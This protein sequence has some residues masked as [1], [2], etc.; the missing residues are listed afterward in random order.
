MGIGGA[1]YFEP[2]TPKKSRAGA[3]A[4]L[5]SF[6]EGYGWLG[7]EVAHAGSGALVAF[8]SSTATNDYPYLDDNGTANTADDRTVNRQNADF[9]AREAWAVG[10]TALGDRGARVTTVFNAFDR[11]QGVSGIAAVPALAAR[12]ETA[13]VL[14]GISAKVPCSSDPSCVL[15]FVTQGISARSSLRDPRRELGLLVTRL[16]SRGDRFGESAR[17]TDA[18]TNWRALFGANFEAESLALDGKSALRAERRTGSARAALGWSLG[19]GLSSDLLA[20]AS[21]DQTRG[22]NGSQAC[23]DL[24]P[25]GRIGARYELGP[26]ALRGNVGR[27]QRVPT[28]GELYGISPLVRGSAALVPERGSIFDLGARSETR[29]GA[30]RAYADAG[31]FVREVSDLIAYRRSSLGAITPYNVGSARVLGAELEAGAES[32]RHYRTSLSLTVLDPRDTT[33][34]RALQNDLVPYQSRFVTS[35]FAEGFVDPHSR[36]VELV[37]LDARYDYRASRFA[38]PAGLIV[39][40]ATSELDLGT[41]LILKRDITVRGAIDDVFDAHHY[42]FIGYPVPGRSYHLSL[43]AWW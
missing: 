25:Q 34:N 9:T 36:S 30:V 35:L 7:G 27:Y 39:L 4:G 17:L 16:D 21:C 32:L 3:G 6:G 37:S 29:L 24:T 31:G 43:E 18:G 40:P 11:E 22:P 12:A 19:A 42:D 28:L 5:G 41:S 10:R 2:R 13:R 20:V 23:A 38:D 33:P 15:E 14:A 1:I 26:V 8:K